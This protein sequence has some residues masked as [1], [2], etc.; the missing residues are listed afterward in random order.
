M[1]P[2]WQPPEQ[3]RCLTLR[4]I[5]SGLN[6]SFLF[7]P[8]APMHAAGSR[9]GAALELY[10]CNSRRWGTLGGGRLLRDGAEANGA[11]LRHGSPEAGLRAP[12]LR[13]ALAVLL[14]GP[15]GQRLPPIAQGRHFLDTYRSYFPFP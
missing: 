9:E 6:A 12:P 15:R 1:W 3:Q 5:P 2:P 13:C 14:S 4:V 7:D 11:K 8:A 10:G